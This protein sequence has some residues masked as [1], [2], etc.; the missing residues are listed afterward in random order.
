MNRLYIGNLSYSATNDELRQLFA[1][2]GNVKEV[3]VIQGRGFGFVEMESEEEAKKAMEA[4]NG[5]DFKGRS[6]KI[7][8]ARE[9]QPRRRY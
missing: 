6:L 1:S 7:D 8:E 9:S 4:L 2:Y 5:K 3:K